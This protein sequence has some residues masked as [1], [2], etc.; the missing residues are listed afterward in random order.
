MCRRRAVIDASSGR[1]IDTERVHGTPLYIIL[2][3]DAAFDHQIRSDLGLGGVG[4]H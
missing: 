3:E 1:S 4:E 2:S